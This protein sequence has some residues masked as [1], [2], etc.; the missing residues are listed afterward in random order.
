MGQQQHIYSLHTLLSMAHDVKKNGGKVV[1]THGAF[2]LFHVGHLHLLRQSAKLGDFFIVGVESDE[3]IR[4]YKDKL[5]RPIIKERER[6]DIISELHSV[7]GVFLIDYKELGN[8]DTYENL[9]KE[10]NIDVVTIGRKFFA[11]D[12]VHNQIRSL[13]NAKVVKIEDDLQSTTGILKGIV[14]KYGN[15]VLL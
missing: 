13:K 9:Y 2:D 4:T 5:Y 12:A 1:I 6:L 11:E 14:S 3:N 15:Q 8:K 7:D 10:F